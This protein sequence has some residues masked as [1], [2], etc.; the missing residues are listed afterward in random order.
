MSNE[1]KSTINLKIGGSQSTESSDMS[2][3]LDDITINPINNSDSEE[4]PQETLEE[5]RK[6]I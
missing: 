4:T 5:T 2:D 6:I 3:D 1:L